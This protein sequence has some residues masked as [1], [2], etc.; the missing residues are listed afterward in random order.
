MH[1]RWVYKLPVRNHCILDCIF[2][3]CRNAY[4]IK[5]GR[6]HARSWTAFVPEPS[7]ALLYTNDF[8]NDRRGRRGEGE[9][10]GV[11]ANSGRYRYNIRGQ[12]RR[13]AVSCGITRG[14]TYIINVNNLRDHESLFYDHMMSLCKTSA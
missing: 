11:V 5:P 9:L 7:R 3:Y 1:L 10:E 4:D 12:S 2:L 13:P 6:G 8:V 14:K